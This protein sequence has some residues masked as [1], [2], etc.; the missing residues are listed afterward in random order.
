MPKRHGHLAPFLA[1]LRERSG[2]SFAELSARTGIALSTL[3]RRTLMPEGMGPDKV[4]AFAA[5]LR[6]DAAELD[7]VRVLDALDRGALPI[8]AGCTEERVAR[9]MAALEGA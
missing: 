5:A 7:R 1:Q 3:H 4:E 2:L 8:P 6:A 9:A